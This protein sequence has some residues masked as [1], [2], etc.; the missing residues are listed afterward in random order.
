MPFTDVIQYLASYQYR[1]NL[2]FQ[3]Q[4]SF[5]QIRIIS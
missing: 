5:V 1:N 4:T 3:I 2:I